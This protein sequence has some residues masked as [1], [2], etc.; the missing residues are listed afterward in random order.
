MQVVSPSLGGGSTSNCQSCGALNQFEH[1]FCAGCG[2]PLIGEASAPPPGPA[3][4]TITV[5]LGGSTP[6]EPIAPADPERPDYLRALIWPFQR[7]DWIERMWWL[8]LVHFV[9]VFNFIIMRGWRL[10]VVRRVSR[11]EPQPIPDLRDFGRFFADGLI[12]WAMTGLYFLPQIFLLALFGFKPIEVGLTVLFWLFQTVTGDAISFGALLA[13]LGL[14]ALVSVILPIVYWLAT[15]P[16]YRVAMVRYAATG[17]VG[18]FF[19]VFTNLRIAGA[20]F[21]AVM[22]LYIFEFLATM[23]FGML[24]SA[25]LSTVFGAVAVPLV[26]FPALYWTTAYLFG[27]FGLHVNA[28]ATK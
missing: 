23:A 10:D 12:L 16:L 20:N 22:T 15:Y 26:L 13:D 21:A 25:L 7:P 28:T 11:N 4:P 1:R 27:V 8:P 19:D 3:S 24:S 18:V 9:P 17:K 6:V 2:T 14:A 5:K